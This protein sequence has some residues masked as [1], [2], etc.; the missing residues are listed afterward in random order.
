MIVVG[1]FPKLSESFVLNHITGLI[2]L[3]VD[4]RVLRTRAGR[5]NTPLDYNRY[6]L[7]ARVASVLPSDS[8]EKVL[9]SLGQETRALA[10]RMSFAFSASSRDDA[11]ISATIEEARQAL[12]SVD[13]RL[14]DIHAA[15]VV[16]R[17]T[18]GVD[19]I[20]CHF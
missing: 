3:G 5:E 15:Q 17:E 2:D 8:D 10:S 4:V 9:R 20:H 7:H 12:D 6:A 14:L 11:G 1:E 16:A 19:V 13:R 18:V